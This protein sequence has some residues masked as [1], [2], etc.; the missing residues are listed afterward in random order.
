M[1]F[2]FL[3]VCAL[4][5]G[6]PQVVLKLDSPQYG[7]GMFSALSTVLG[8]LDSYE[9]FSPKERVGIEIDFA[10]GGLYYDPAVGSNWWQYYFEPI[11]ASHKGEVRRI[12][13]EL[14]GVLSIYGLHI[15]KERSHELV[16]RYFKVKP[17]VQQK[18]DEFVSAHFTAPLMVGI[19]YRGTDKI[20]EARRLEY[21]VMCGRILKALREQVKSFEEI[22]LFVASDEEAFIAYMKNHFGDLVVHTQS[23][24][25]TDGQPTHYKMVDNY[26][27]GEEALID[28]LLLSRCNMVIRN[29]SNLGA[30]V[31]KFN[32]LIAE[33]VLVHQY[34][35]PRADTVPDTIPF[36]P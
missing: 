4:L 31:S 24:R 28:C 18:V 20:G 35:D 15:E 19:H 21:S 8:F 26:A 27:K 11:V 9:R 17:H 2:L 1:R 34:K 29:A 30:F 12:T 13:E 36:R 7:A 23:R 33:T 10:D 25:S 16:A 6:A 5:N 3:F 14:K 22:K 32:P